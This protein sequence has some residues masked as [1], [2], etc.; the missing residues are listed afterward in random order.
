MA[1]KVPPVTAVNVLLSADSSMRKVRSALAP[2]AVPARM[3]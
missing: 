2:A 3:I 1:V